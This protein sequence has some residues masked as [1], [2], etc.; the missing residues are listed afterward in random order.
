MRRTPDRHEE[1]REP[2]IFPKKTYLRA[3]PPV[4]NRLEAGVRRP[5]DKSMATAHPNPFLN[6]I[7]HLIRSV[8]AAAMTDSQ[9]L[10]RFVANGDETAFEVLVRRYGPLV[11]G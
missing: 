8:P 3:V 5:E 4:S 7:R 2:D 1:G 11:L 6:H 10:E 9:L